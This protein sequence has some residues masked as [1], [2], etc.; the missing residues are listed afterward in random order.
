MSEE[1]HTGNLSDPIKS[2]WE[3]LREKIEG[4]ADTSFSVRKGYISWK[5]DNTAVCFIHFRK[6]E[7]RIDILRGT[8]KEDGVESRG[9]FNLDD[10]KEMTND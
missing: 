9:F 3:T 7:L 8:I 2:I 1:D 4:Y 5:K 6:K 10:P